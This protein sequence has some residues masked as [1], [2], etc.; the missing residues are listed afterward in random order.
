[1]TMK[2]ACV[3]PVLFFFACSPVLG[4][5]GET[6]LPPPVVPAGFGVN[7]HFTD[8]APGEMERFAEAGYRLVRMDFAWGAIE[9]EPGPL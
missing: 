7:I 1:M 5:A 3:W 9:S 2:R 4:V 8:P 6:G